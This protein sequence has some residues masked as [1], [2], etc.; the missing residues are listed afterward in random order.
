MAA[1][2]YDSN[3]PITGAEA[4]QIVGSE[5]KDFTQVTGDEKAAFAY[6]IR[7]CSLRNWDTPLYKI[8]Y[9]TVGG[10]RRFENRLKEINS[11]YDCCAGHQP[12]NVIVVMVAKVTGRPEEREIHGSLKTYNVKVP[13]RV[14]GV[15]KEL[16]RVDTSV[17]DYFKAYCM[18]YNY[19]LWESDSY[20]L[21][22]DGGET[23][24]GEPIN[25]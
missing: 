18:A 20:V 3:P 10:A 4:A 13:N 12:Q 25:D 16:Y 5:C 24:D 22:D 17:Y 15:F 23:W 8:G 11:Q 6:L 7:I 14:S 21:G 1:I 19:P 9:C 2:D